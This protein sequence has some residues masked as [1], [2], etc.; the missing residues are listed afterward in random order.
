MYGSLKLFGLTIV[1][2]CNHS[3]VYELGVRTSRSFY[4][5]QKLL[6]RVVLFSSSLWEPRIPV[7][8]C[9]CVALDLTY[10]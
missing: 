4:T 6:Q 8:M 10:R 2:M 5:Q 3:N 1:L 9:V 7:I